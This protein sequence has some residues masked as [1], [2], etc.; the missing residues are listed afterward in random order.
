MPD[1]TAAL[2]AL[3]PQPLA[4]DEIHL[5][6]CEFPPASPRIGRGQAQAFLL[7]LLSAY[8]RRAVDAAELRI[9]DYGK[10]ALPHADIAFNLSHSGRAALVALARGVAVGVDLETFG[11]PRAHVELAR[12]YF[13]EHEALLVE[14]AAETARESTF[15]R[16]W[17]AK[18]AVLKALGRGLAFGLDKLEFDLATHPPTLLRIAA[19][20]SDAAQWRLHAVPLP[21][22]WLG[23]L[24]WHGEP[25]RVVCFQDVTASLP[26]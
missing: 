7:R 6:F 26:A 1:R 8:L 20:G 9:G 3:P 23:H 24:A 2:P 11:R 13:C 5:W 19:A 16:L 25:R 4:S 10:P 21:A 12:R 15:L 14:T 22:P 18:E 17:T